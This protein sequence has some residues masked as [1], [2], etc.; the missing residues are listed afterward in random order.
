MT[1]YF[2]EK[3]RIDMVGDLVEE[4]KKKTQG[5][6]WEEWCRRREIGVE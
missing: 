6:G 1:G 3:K 5:S 2:E 4:E